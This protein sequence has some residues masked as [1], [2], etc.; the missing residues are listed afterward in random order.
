M[1]SRSTGSCYGRSGPSGGR[2]VGGM[3]GLLLRDGVKYKILYQTGLKRATRQAVVIYAGVDEDGALMFRSDSG[4]ILA[5]T[6]PGRIDGAE[7]VDSN[8]PTYYDAAQ[9]E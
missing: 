8:V 1:P 7:E 2:I 6:W 5:K 3:D 4:H 9:D